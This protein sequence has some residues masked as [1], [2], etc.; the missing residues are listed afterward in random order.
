MHRMTLRTSDDLYDALRE[1]ARARGFSTSAWITW[2]LEHRPAREEVVV[3]ARIPRV[4]PQDIASGSPALAA[5]AERGGTPVRPK[6]VKHQFAQSGI[7]TVCHLAQRN[8][9]DSCPGADSR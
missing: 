8:A 9:P 5:V 6:P 2:L 7:C 1:E 4:S 3:E